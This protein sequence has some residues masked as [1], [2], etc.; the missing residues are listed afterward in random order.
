M[1]TC[2]EYLEQHIK[3]GKV[4]TDH[5]VQYGRHQFFKFKPEWDNN[6]AYW[7]P[8]ILK[9]MKKNLEAEWRLYGNKSTTSSHRLID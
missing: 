6:V 5:A 3:F 8:L 2:K 9:V 4:D 7:G 1:K